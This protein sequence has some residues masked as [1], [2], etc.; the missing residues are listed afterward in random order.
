[1]SDTLTP[2]RIQAHEEQYP[3]PQGGGAWLVPSGDPS[4]MAMRRRD[5]VVE[6]RNPA[7]GLGWFRLNIDFWATHQPIPCN[8]QGIPLSMLAEMEALR[9]SLA[10]CKEALPEG[11][12]FDP[13]PQGIAALLKANRDACKERDNAHQRGFRDEMALHEVITERDAARAE[14][15]EMRAEGARLQQRIG[16]LEQG[17]V[18]NRDM[19]K[20]ALVGFLQYL[21]KDDIVFRRPNGDPVSIGEALEMLERNDP[22]MVEFLRD[23]YAVAVRAVWVKSK[24]PTP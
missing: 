23:V 18:A 7:G 21:D 10:Q 11:Y 22:L 17:G 13:V 8:Q 19:V 24:R 5:G 9:E 15:A 12:R 14:T 3:L 4:I 6:G 20:D 1:M 2:E 16:E